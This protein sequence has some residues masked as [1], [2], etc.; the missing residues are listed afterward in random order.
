MRHPTVTVSYII[1]NCY[2][3]FSYSQYKLDITILE[4]WTLICVCTVFATLLTYAI[5]LG[6][7]QMIIQVSPRMS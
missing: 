3:C 6:R 5:I 1:G 2:Q 7:D 4:L